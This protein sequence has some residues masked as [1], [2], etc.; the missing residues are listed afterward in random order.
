MRLYYR[1]SLETLENLIL[2][3]MRIRVSTFDTVNDPFELLAMSQTDKEGR[4][5]FKWLYDY[6]AASL[7]FISMSE[8]WKSPLMWA[9]YAKNHTGVCLGLEL[10]DTRAM[11]VNYQPER[12]KAALDAS[13]LETAVDDEVIRTAVTT[14]FREWEYER[15][16]RML[17]Q[18]GAPDEDTGMHYVDFSPDF[19]LRE[20]I[21]GARCKRSL[22]DIRNQVFANT[23]E[24][25]L[26]AARPAFQSFSMVC[27]K[28]A[29]SMTIGPLHGMPRR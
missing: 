2:P 24:I 6:W 25:V 4:K 9:H 10:P 23:G 12:L 22:D 29:T 26:K 15:E 27:Q 7:G 19:E 28:L 11:K 3:E 13:K 8:H 1:T 16:W 5:S 20:I 21:T 14:K 17:V 18:L